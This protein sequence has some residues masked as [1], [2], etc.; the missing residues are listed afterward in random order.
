V[1]FLRLDADGEGLDGDGPVVVEQGEPVVE[2][3]VS[4]IL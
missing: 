1:E 4:S 3:L 2:A